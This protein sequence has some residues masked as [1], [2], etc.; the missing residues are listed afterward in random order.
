MPFVS[1]VEWRQANLAVVNVYSIFVSL[2]GPFGFGMLFETYTS[3]L[4][5]LGIMTVLGGASVLLAS[6][7]Q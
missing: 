3:L 4:S 7:L 6:K 2:A 1:R 5:V